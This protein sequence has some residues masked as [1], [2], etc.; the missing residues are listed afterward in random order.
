MAFIYHKGEGDKDSQDGALQQDAAEEKAGGNA[1]VSFDTTMHTPTAMV[2]KFADSNFPG[3]ADAETPSV[4][5]CAPIDVIGGKTCE[6]SGDGNDVVD[7]SKEEK[8]GG[9]EQISPQDSASSVIT[10]MAKMSLGELV[11][12]MH[13]LGMEWS[14]GSDAPLPSPH[15]GHKRTNRDNNFHTSEGFS[16]SSS[17]DLIS[18]FGNSFPSQEDFA[19]GV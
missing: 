17:T 3:R 15:L 4:D 9:S 10:E 7:S 5:K 11:S 8:A 13:M 2:E 16:S 19:Q 6:S 12:H 18:P 1:A 14:P